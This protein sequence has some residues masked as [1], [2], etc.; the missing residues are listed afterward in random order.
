STTVGCNNGVQ[1]QVEAGSFAAVF[2]P[3]TKTVYVENQLSASM[4]VVNGA[5]CNAMNDSGCNQKPPFLA[6]GIDP[7]PF[8]T[9]QPHKRSMFPARTQTSP[10]FSTALG[11]T[12]PGLT[13]APRTRP[14]RLREMVHQG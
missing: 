6:T 2:D 11:A 8:V 14:L 9:I 3:Q 1:V 4:S 10:G 7:A 12:R 5:T 13:A